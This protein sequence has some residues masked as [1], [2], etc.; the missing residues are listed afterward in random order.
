VEAAAGGVAAPEV[1]RGATPALRAAP[2]PALAGFASPALGARRDAPSAVGSSAAAAA[3]AAA[4]GGGAA[5][6]RAARFWEVRVA[7]P[8]QR[9][10]D[11]CLA[12]SD[13][14]DSALARTTRA[15]HIRTLAE[16]LERAAVASGFASAAG[17]AAAAAALRAA[18]PA[19]AAPP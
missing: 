10:A 3:A 1:A 11:G 17:G 4:A 19:P 18:L 13:L 6:L 2:T 5:A 7:P 14:I 15:A 9:A 8:A 16:A 12:P